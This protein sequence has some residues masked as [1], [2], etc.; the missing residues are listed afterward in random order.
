MGYL[1]LCSCFFIYATVCLLLFVTGTYSAPGN[2][3][4]ELALLHFKAGIVD[5]FGVMTSW[6]DTLDF[7]QW[8]GVTCSRRH[9]R[10]TELD[11]NSSKL[12]GTISPYIGNLSFLKVLDLQNNSFTHNI[13]PEIGSL[14]RLQRLF[15]NNNSLTGEIPSNI[16]RCSNLIYLIIYNNHLIGKIPVELGYL[17]KLQFLYIQMNNLAGTLPHSLGNLSSLIIFAAA[18]NNFVG[19][20]PYAFGKLKSLT[21]LGLPENKL[22][23]FIP[24]TVFN[25]S[26]IT[27]LDIGD[28]NFTGFLPADLF[29]S[30]PNLQILSFGYNQFTGP[31]PNSISNASNLFRLQ[32]Q[33]NNLKGKVPSL[34]TLNVDLVYIEDNH[35]GNVQVDDL[36]FL[37]SLTNS[38]ILQ[39]LDISQNNFGGSLPECIG[40]LSPN[41]QELSLGENQIS[42]SIPTSIGNLVNLARIEVDNNKLSGMI[43][44]SIGN[45]QNA[46]VMIFNEN[47]FFGPIPSSLGNLTKLN[48]LHF[49]GNNL[50]GTIPSS[51]ANCTSLQLLDFSR[52]NLSGV[53]PHQVIGLSSLSIHAG[54]AQ[55]YFT[56]SLPTELGNLKS[57]G[58][59]DVSDN[60]LSG[61]IPSS[62]GSCTSLE[63]LYMEDNRFHGSIPISLSSLRGLQFLNFSHNNLSGKIPGF[64]AS[65]NSL[66]SLD[67]SFNDFEGIVPIGGVFKNASITSVMGNNKL[68]GGIPEF[69]LP[70]CHLKRSNKR[71]LKV[72]IATIAGISGA[73]FVALSSLFL[74]WFKKK[75]QKPA[76]SNSEI[77][78]LAVLMMSYK[79][80]HKATDGFL[81][82][83]LIGSGSFGSVYKGILNEGRQMIAVKVL[84]LQYHGAA[85]S[86]IA[87]CEA[88]RNIRHRNLVKIV[89]A[90]SGV[91]YKG[92]DFK[93]LV[94]EFMVNGSLEEWLHPSVVAIN[95]KQEGHDILN[96]IQRINIAID[97]ASAI[98][99]LH[100]HSGTPIVH[101]DLKPSNVLL[102]DEMTAHIGDFGLAK[103][104]SHSIQNKFTTQSS[105]AGLRGTIGY[106]PPEYGLGSEV[107]K[108]GDVYSYGILL[109]EMFTRKRPTDDM[110]KEGWN[111]HKF[112]KSAFP[113]G[114]SAIVD[115]I[116]IQEGGQ[117]INK[118][119][120]ECLISIL[121][122]GICCSAESP[123]DRMNIGDVA[124]KLCLI[125]DRLNNSRRRNARSSNISHEPSQ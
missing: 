92:N 3:T 40:N 85:K 35:L 70:I 51:L 83:N 44:Q 28:N 63:Y 30:L 97:V 78:R 37:C 17:S 99:Y 109:L 114:V 79:D 96:L 60:M 2:E 34:E 39:G 75:R 54:F 55:N 6:N 26:S 65:F 53:I 25:V 32:L 72:I 81:S 119:I 93:A 59:L 73:F 64:L 62:L 9:Q 125:R 7:C 58:T 8:Y 57:L 106:A 48:R 43:P 111:L 56:G 88:L 42:G 22:S 77:S 1:Y 115:P 86:F 10:V 110:F 24:S 116:L 101:C 123:I 94:Y 112:V 23:G 12:A 117:S 100:H 49:A 18:Y 19:N 108:Q 11:L 118:I 52:N 98:E 90:C 61:E 14:R 4:D 82:A 21:F 67:L 103:F 124:I 120:M 41:L 69:Q 38:S 87:E 68:C 80:L 71:K 74:L 122:I 15:L 31:I 50:Q 107:S 104:L 105:S 16:S 13:P 47:N 33:G 36:R 5:P 66:L 29:T 91:D 76:S 27:V 84:N 113:N 46:V 102:D 121:E 95:G 89:T 20:I 45:L